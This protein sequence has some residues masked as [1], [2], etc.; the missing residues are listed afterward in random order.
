MKF[1]TCLLNSRF[2]VLVI[3]SCLFLIIND[4]KSQDVQRNWGNN[5]QSLTGNK[6]FNNDS[7]KVQFAIVSDLWGG[8]RPGVFDDAVEK[9]NLLQPQFVMSV[10]D[11]IDGKTTDNKEWDQQ[12][13]EF[14]TIK[15]RLEVPFY[16][17]PGNHDIS[18]KWMEDKWKEKYGNPYYHF[19]CKNVLFLIINTQDGGN[20]RI[21]DEQVKYFKQ[22]ID[23]NKKVRWTFVFLHRPVWQP[24]RMEKN[25]E[26]IEEALSGRKY[27]L[28][29]GHFH[30]YLNLKKGN[31]D[32]F[33][34]STTG[35]GSNLRGEHLGEFDHITWVTLGKEEPQIVNIKLDGIIKKDIV[36][37]KNYKV[38]EAITR[39]TWLRFSADTIS[40]KQIGNPS[41][42]FYN[43]TDHEMSIYSDFLS[44]PLSVSDKFVRVTLSAGDSLKLPIAVQVTKAKNTLKATAKFA[45]SFTNV[46]GQNFQDKVERTIYFKQ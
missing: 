6:D 44:L 31:N 27:T 3:F 26:R 40:L 13:L 25:Y 22:V 10:G 17:V 33:I 15:D 5:A 35:G 38:V 11:L 24:G 39:E 16:Y 14:N 23:D 9:L 45:C 34:L 18:N 36:N 21:G 46:H 37:E 42:T 32:H 8:Y 20:S 43:N 12:W 7:S 1:L 29:S 19:I 4:A 41:V 28:F 2:N 30:T